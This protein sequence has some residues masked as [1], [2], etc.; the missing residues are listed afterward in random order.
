M[1]R[2]RVGDIVIDGTDVSIGGVTM[3][4]R[5]QALSAPQPRSSR[6]SSHPVLPGPIARLVANL[7]PRHLTMFGGG[8]AAVGAA[9]LVLGPAVDG[10]LAF[11]FGGGLFL[12]A[13]GGAAAAGLLLTWSARERATEALRSEEAALAAGVARLRSILRGAGADQ[14]YERLVKRSGLSESMVVRSLRALR[15]SGELIED[16]NTETGD[17]F[18]ALQPVERPV[19][20]PRNLEDRIGELERSGE[21]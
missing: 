16:L 13:G 11:V 21:S 8:L 5:A 15:D 12:T 19:V 9:L 3:T 6:P 7:R 14:T 4:G 20:A 10:V 2:L 18:Y 1:S 17:F